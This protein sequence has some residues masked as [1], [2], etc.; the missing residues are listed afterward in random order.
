MFWIACK[1]FLVLTLLTG[2]L[3][4]LL[5]TLIATITMPYQSYGSL[6][7][8][9]QQLRGSE[10]IV[11]SFTDS[12]YF[13]P[14]PS[15]AKNNPLLSQA[16]NWGPTSREL[17]QEVEQRAQKLAQMHSVPPSSIPTDLLYASGSGLD[18]HISLEAAYFQMDRV[19]RA[20]AL[21]P[22]DKEK[23]QQLIQDFTESKL[24]ILAPPHVNVLL[25]NKELDQQFSSRF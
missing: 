10:L 21:S 1:I 18:P 15:A 6:I 14:R 7:F 22:A 8:Q 13:W 17:K 2:C 5:I 16:S 4:P 20:R 3:Y 12:R 11:Q 24:G 19:A 9:N 23:L 25:L